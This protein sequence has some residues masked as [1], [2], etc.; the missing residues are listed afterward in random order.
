MAACRGF[1]V[2]IAG[3]GEYLDE[4]GRIWA[5]ATAFRDGSPDVAPLDAARAVIKPVVGSSAQSLLLVALG[6]DNDALGFAVAVTA[7]PVH[8]RRAELRYLGV[9]PRAWGGG[10]AARLLAALRDALSSRGFVEAELWVYCDNRR[11][12]DLYRRTQWRASAD[13]R[14]HPRS[15][16]R[17]Q[18]YTLTIATEPSQKD[19]SE[20]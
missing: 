16:R 5:E 8:D 9:R 17:E 15:G 18:R 6:N 7:G 11:A 3:P 2:V 13:V 10:I 14:I 1:D 12:I 19:R 4:A 20:P